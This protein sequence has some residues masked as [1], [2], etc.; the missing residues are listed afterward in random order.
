MMMVSVK[1]TPQTVLGGVLLAAACAAGTGSDGF[2]S[3]ASLGGADGTTAGDDS[4]GPGASSEPGDDGAG[5]VDANTG[6][7][8]S[9]G[10]DGPEP[11]SNPG[12]MC[13]GVDDDGNGLIDDGLGELGCGM[14]EC[15]TV[16]PACIDGAPNPC[17]PGTPAT[18]VCNGL[19]DDCDGSTDEEVTQAC[20]TACGSGS[21]T[22]SGGVFAGCDAPQPG[23]ESCNAS[24]DDCDGQ[25]DEGVDACR[26]GIHRSWHP[27]TG[28]HFYTADLGEAGCCGFQVEFANFFQLYDAQQ[29]STTLFYRCIKAN[30]FHFYTAD[31]GC[32]GQIMEGP[33]GWIGTS[34]TAGAVALYRSYREANG[35][36]FYTN[37]QA[38]HQSAITV[39]GYIDEGVVGWVW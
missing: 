3:A 26:H 9:A 18:E 20:T 38:E 25:Y 6:D 39:S 31:P 7:D 30:G 17:T 36:H 10:D 8:T 29:P 32:E 1:G 19:D 12:E 23:A 11:P 5:D 15:A 35:D 22:C 28:E 37:S 33:I 4:G 13:N 27:V 34:E 14:G 21:E 16:V 24:D 2:T